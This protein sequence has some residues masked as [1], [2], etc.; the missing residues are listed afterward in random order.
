MQA[1]KR[2]ECEIAASCRE[3]CIRRAATEVA[4][5]VNARH[6]PALRGAV[7]EHETPR[8]ALFPFAQGKI[9]AREDGFVER[10]VAKSAAFGGAIRL[11]ACIERA[12]IESRVIQLHAFERAAFE[13]AVLESRAEQDGSIE[14]GVN[15]CTVAE[16]QG[17]IGK[18]RHIGGLDARSEQ[19][20]VLLEPHADRDAVHSTPPALNTGELARAVVPLPATETRCVT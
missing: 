20:L 17:A 4:S 11:H 16:G 8:G 6:G 3:G 7:V 2:C 15:E 13:S 1:R 5:E 12:V 10:V 9:A 18:A 19:A 14:I